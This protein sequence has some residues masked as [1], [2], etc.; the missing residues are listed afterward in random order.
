[1]LLPVAVLQLAWSDA[2][3]RWLW[4]LG[5]GAE[6]ALLVVDLQRALRPFGGLRW[7]Q[8]AAFALL[9]QRCIAQNLTHGQL[10]LWVGACMLR[11]VVLLQERRDVRGGVWLG[12]AAALKLTPFLFAVALPFMRRGR[13]AAVTAIVALGLVYL[14]PWPLLGGEHWRH[15]GDFHRAMIAPLL[16]PGEGPA[17][18]VL[19]FRAGANVGGTFDYLLQPRPFDVDGRRQNVLDV[20]DGVLRAVKLGWSA[21]LLALLGLMCWRARRLPDPR[22]LAVEASAVMLA[23]ALFSPLTR[24]YHLAGALLP[25]ALFCRG[26][27]RP[28]R[29]R[30]DWLWWITAFALLFCLTLRQRRLLGETW[31]RALDAGGALHFALVGLLVW[32]ALADHR[33]PRP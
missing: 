10:S 19:E 15:V 24:V 16:G 31:W 30:R 14:L 28:G 1:V 11:G 22:R 5:L 27:G 9:F 26:P 13:A 3:I 29:R 33:E 4:C 6:T 32:L 21:L 25:F 17:G 12:V 18:G 2:V 8:W 7:W 20:S 23:I